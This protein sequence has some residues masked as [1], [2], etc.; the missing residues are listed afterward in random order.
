MGDSAVQV[1]NSQ[2]V[3]YINSCIGHTYTTNVYTPGIGWGPMSIGPS[4][5]E[6]KKQ[7]LKLLL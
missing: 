5:K 1:Y 7:K 4:I 2:Q 6:L 3:H